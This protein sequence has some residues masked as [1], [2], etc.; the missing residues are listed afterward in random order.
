MRRRSDRGENVV[1]KSADKGRCLGIYMKRGFMEMK[2]SIKQL[3][4]R[5]FF[6][7]Q[8]DMPFPD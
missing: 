6:L 3:D 4:A 8:H 2:P 5:A 1:L 7:Q